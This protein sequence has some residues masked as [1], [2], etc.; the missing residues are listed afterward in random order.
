MRFSA[1]C[2]FGLQLAAVAEVAGVAEARHDVFVLVHSRVDGRAPHGCLVVGEGLLDMLDALGRGYHAGHVYALGRAVGKEGL[3]AQLH[4][5][6]RGQHG[7][8]YD[9]RLAVD[10]G[11][12]E[13]FHVYAHF[14]VAVVLVFAVRAYEG[15]AGVV[16]HVQ[17]AVVERQSGTE[18]RSQYYLVGR[19]IDLS[20]AQRRL[21]VALLIVER[22]AYL[23]GHHLAHARNIITE[24]QAVKLIFLVAHL[25]HVLVEDSV[26]IT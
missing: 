20:R 16:K 23:V 14:C 24:K 13:V 18:N 2:L 9:E 1:R 15:V 8:G 17:E 22:L 4:R 7:V 6:A 11:R 3:V 21:N 19:H 12:G 25:S 5:A 10:R 26:L